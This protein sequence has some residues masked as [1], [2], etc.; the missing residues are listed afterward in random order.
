VAP[1]TNAIP[2]KPEE[3]KTFEHFLTTVAPGDRANIKDVFV[4]KGDHWIVSEPTLLL[5]CSDDACNGLRKFSVSS[6]DAYI[7]AGW[8]FKYLTYTCRNCRK[9]QK[10]F[11]LALQSNGN[12]AGS[13]EKIGEIPPFGPVTPARVIK[14]VGPDKELYL[15]GRR[16]EINGLGIGAFTYYRRV[17]EDQKGR[18]IGEIARVAKQ[19]KASPE[20]MKLFEDAAAD[21]QF[22][23]AVETIK[24]AI[25]E[26]LLVGG[27]NPLTLLH[28]TLSQAIHNKTD[29]DCLALATS[30]R[31]LL[32]E[33]AER[34]AQAL[35]DDAELQKAL[36][37]LLNPGPAKPTQS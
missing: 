9:A 22:K 34:L 2:D 11:S 3:A 27:H 7:D 28:G 10:I 29:A 24:S 8:N 15:K 36:S 21:N 18:I 31:V 33:L 20:T 16:A 14:L 25:P 12:A 37:T 17:V 30:V 32:N 4:R 13:V 19:L 23:S 6:S 35:K 26:G 1:T 5:Y